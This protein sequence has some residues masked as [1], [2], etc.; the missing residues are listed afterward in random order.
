[1]V[2]KKGQG[3]FFS[4]KNGADVYFSHQKKGAM[5]SYS[6]SIIQLLLNKIIFLFDKGNLITAGWAGVMK[7]ISSYEM[8]DLSISQLLR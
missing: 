3:P 1:M 7:N 6:V 4:K 5:R 8:V 2:G